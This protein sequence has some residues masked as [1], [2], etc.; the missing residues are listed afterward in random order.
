MSVFSYKSHN[1]YTSVAICN[2]QCSNIHVPIVWC[3]EYSAY[4]CWR[5]FKLSIFHISQCSW[6]LVKSHTMNDRWNSVI[7][8]FLY[9]LTS[10]SMKWE[11]CVICHVREIKSFMSSQGQVPAVGSGYH[12]FNENAMQ[13]LW[14]YSRPVDTDPYQLNDGEDTEAVLR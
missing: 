7:Q 8:V 6:H 5:V 10:W 3:T 12:N 1:V 13:F 11:C 14:I 4:I 9:P 2:S